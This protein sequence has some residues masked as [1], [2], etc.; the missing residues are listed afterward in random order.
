MGLLAKLQ[1]LGCQLRLV[2][3]VPK[4]QTA[5]TKI[6]TRSV[7][8]QELTTQLQ[9]ENVRILAE[10]PVELTIDFERIFETAGIVGSLLDGR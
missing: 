3:M 2:Q 8:L 9:T 7:T 6:E 5:P 1:A 4:T 10:S